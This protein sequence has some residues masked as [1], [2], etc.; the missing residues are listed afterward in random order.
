MCVRVGGGG[1]DSCRYILHEAIDSAGIIRK[2]LETTLFPLFLHG[3]T[4]RRG[5]D[6]RLYRRMRGRRRSV[7]EMDHAPT[8]DKMN[9]DGGGGFPPVFNNVPSCLER[10]SPSRI[11]VS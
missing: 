1:N 5:Q 3:F 6:I 11:A 4:I 10:C 8:L 7:K 9:D 2:I